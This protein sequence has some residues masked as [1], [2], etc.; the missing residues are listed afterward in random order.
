MGAHLA[1]RLLRSL[2]AVW[3]VAP[4]TAVAQGASQAADT[5]TASASFPADRFVAGDAAITFTLTR[6]IGPAEGRV[7][8]MIGTLDVSALVERTATTVTYRPRGIR[9]PSGEHEVVLYLVTDRAW[10]AIGRAP[11]KVLAQGG[12]TSAATTPSA[13]LNMK[14]QLAEGHSGQAPEPE[15][16]TYQDFTLTGGLQSAH[17]RGG[18]TLRTQ[19]N[20]LGAS[21]REEA[22]RYGLLQDNAPRIDLSDYAVQLERGRV[23]FG[24]GHVSTGGNRH[25]MNAFASRGV[26][27]AVRGAVANL[28]VAAVNGSS[29]VG[30]NNIS[31]LENGNH[32]LYSATVG[33][34]LRPQRPGALHLDAT[35][36]DGSLLPQTS[37]TQG[38]VVDAERSTGGGVQLA[39][40][41]PGQRLRLAAGLSRSRFDNPD[42]DVQLEGELPIVSV[43]RETR[44]AQYAELGA[45]LLQ[46]ATLPKLFATTLNAG[47]RYERVDPLYR[48]IGTFVQADRLQHGFDV[49][50]NFGALSV[51]L[52][53]ARGNDNL[54]GLASMLTTRTR[55]STATASLPLAGLLRVRRH[56]AWWPLLAYGQNWTRQFGTGV[57]VNGDFSASHVPDQVSVIHDA[58]IAWQLAKWR[59]QYR[60]NQSDQDNRQTGRERADLTG[61]MNTVSLGLMPHA[62]V[63]LSVDASQERQ[64]NHELAQIARVRRVGG[65]VNWRATPLT[66]LTAFGSVSVS[67]N[68]PSTDDADNAEMRF[69]LA[70]GFNLWRNAE[71]RGSRGQLFLRYANQSSTLRRYSVTV[72]NAVLRGAA[73]DT[74]TLSSGAS[75]RLF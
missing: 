19:S 74:W 38:A 14:G 21:R 66:T 22:L 27:A 30:W 1:N 42:R 72:P 23:A 70:R 37:F 54:D 58:S 11:I 46:S 26:S 68:E 56:T 45:T 44:E 47:Y 55:M 2:A 62:N 20:Y 18:W 24:L 59:L 53:H 6:P 35:M 31:G 25:L 63:D 48:S 73:R 61:T 28:A 9:L 34:E 33:L 64:A 5:V 51:Q 49:G 7:A 57:P 39:A 12:F 60:F 50:G 69:E 13:A 3:A 67:S 8:L 15:R 71:G 41:T 40:S 29:I 16:P 36:V 4:L 65:S 43:R 75:L 32:R 52:T 10:N 17:V